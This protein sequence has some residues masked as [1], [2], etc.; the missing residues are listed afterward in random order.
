MSAIYALVDC[1]NF[2]VSCE[3]VFAPRWEGQP[4]VVLSN[5]DGC[6]VARSDEAK[7]LGIRMGVPVFQVRDLIEKHGVE[8]FSSNYTL[9]ADMSRRVME[10]LAGFAPAMEVYSIDEAFLDLAG[11]RADRTEYARQIRRRVRQ[12]VGIPVTI[13]LGP[14]KT[15]AKVANHL[16][17]WSARA[18][19]VLDL[20]ECPYLAE[21]LR[22][23]PVQ[24]VWGVGPQYARRLRQAGIQTAWDLRSAGDA[25]IRRELGVT[26][27][28]TV[29]EL[30]GIACYDL[31]TSAPPN[32][33]I[34]NSRSFGRPVETLAELQE[35]VAA[36]MSRAARKL[37]RQH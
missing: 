8:V 10:T 27:L 21:A 30:R 1:N 6:V 5:N 13:G 2:Y 25:W 37:R 26:G 24:D 29:H 7:A 18:Q 9:Y 23:T 14:S 15:L 11:N 12:W 19:G 32:Q 33:G 36:Y 4:V 16:A 28:R 35:A 31:E 3:R 34:A 22:R 17:K 20:T